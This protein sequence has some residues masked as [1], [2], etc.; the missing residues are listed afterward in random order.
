MNEI[1]EEHLS[2]EEELNEETK[3]EEPKLYDSDYDPNMLESEWTKVHNE[4]KKRRRKQ[5]IE[6][7][8]LSEENF[9]SLIESKNQD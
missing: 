9:L 1:D 4:R 8:D 5:H 2:A 7:K 3:D 6:L